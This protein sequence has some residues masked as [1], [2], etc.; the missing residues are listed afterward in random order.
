MAQ[1]IVAA[2]PATGHFTPMR[3]IA[4]DLVRRGHE[5][6]VTTGSRFR[7]SVEATGARFVP[8]RGAAD[9]D[10]DDE[11]TNFPEMKD[12]P[13]GPERLGFG[14]RNTFIRQIPDQHRTLQDIMSE[15]DGEPVVLVHELAFF[16]G[17]PVLLGAPGLRPEATIAVGVV[18]L[19]ITSE[20]TAPFGMALPPDS[21]PEGRARNRAANEA[22]RGLFAD[23]QEYL[24]E[25]LA[26]VGATKEPPFVFDSM[27]S[28]PDEFLQLSIE[29]MDYPRSDLPETVRYIGALPVGE[30][31]DRPLPE[32]WQDV[33][34]ARTVVVVSQGTIANNDLTELVQPTLDVLADQDVLVVATLGR[35][36]TLDR[37]PA[38]ARVAEF[39]P[40]G[41]L[42]PHADVLVGNGGFGGVQQAL[43]LGV[44]LVL[45][46]LTEDKMEVTA[47]AAWTGAAINLATQRPDPADL[48]KAVS[49]VL[50]DQSYR[51]RAEE[52]AAEFDRH[53]PFA[54]IERTILDR[55]TS[56]R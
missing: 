9:F 52:L 30:D 12:I 27:A 20:D 55:L 14:L 11:E 23:T 48:A 46:G 24:Q 37:V 31:G 33:L 44:P 4:A 29:S 13:P 26:S 56:A 47:R 16:G 54:A 42:L 53:D 21:S 6:T 25:V 15:M 2:S 7:S 38:N 1:I 10:A 5:V 35:D 8:L 50:T 19:A 17:W 51:R 41:A 43:R 49:A 40:F 22:M 45:A 32:W 28:V 34:D 36:A 3:A 18:P 39:V